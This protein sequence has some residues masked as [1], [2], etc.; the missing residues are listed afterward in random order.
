MIF[1]LQKIST[2]FTDA[3]KQETIPFDYAQIIQPLASI[4]LGER[5]TVYTYAY[6]YSVYICILNV[7][8]KHAQKTSSLH[9]CITRERESSL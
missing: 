3:V 2:S 7:P 1:S 8:T 4:H 5:V 6:S 9:A